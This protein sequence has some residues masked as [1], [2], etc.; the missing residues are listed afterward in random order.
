MQTQQFRCPT[1]KYRGQCPG[2]YEGSDRDTYKSQTREK[3]VLMVLKEI[4][5]HNDSNN[6]VYMNSRGQVERG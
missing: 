4:K 2:D 5:S 1:Q 3:E 6:H